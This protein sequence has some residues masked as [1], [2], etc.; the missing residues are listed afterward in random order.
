[1]PG[2]IRGPATPVIPTTVSTTGPAA[3]AQPAAPSAP[4]TSPTLRDRVD[5][6]VDKLKGKAVKVAMEEVAK[7]HDLGQGASFGAFSGTVKL[8]ERI[9]LKDTRS[10]KALV[11]GDR[12]RLDHTKSNPDAVWVKSGALVGASAGFPLGGASVGFNGS[13]EVTSIAAHDVNG[14][15]DVGAAVKAQ[16]K[17]MVLPLDAEGLQ[18]LEAAPGS[19]WMFRGTA[20]ASVSAGV[21]TSS[22]VGNDLYSASVN[23]GASV[24][25][26]AN[27]VFTKNVKVLE[28]GKVYVQ[29]ARQNN[30]SV[31]GSLGL[32][33][34]VRI[35]AGDEASDAVGGG[36]GG[37]VADRAAD[38]VGD[39]ITDLTAVDASVNASVSAHQKVLGAAVLD[40]NTPHGRQAYDLIIRSRPDE[41]A[42]Y[43][44]SSGL[45]VKYAE[46]GSAVNSGASLRFGDTNL[47]ATSTMKGTTNGTLEEPGGTTLLSQADFGRNVGGALPRL[48]IGEERQ[49][50]VRAG[51]VTRNGT[52]EQGLTLSLKVQDPKLKQGELAQ[53]DRFAKGMGTPLDKL[54]PLNGSGHAGKATYDVQVALTDSHLTQF[55]NR[56]PDDMKLAFG[57]ALKEIDGSATMP[58]WLEDPS[59]F[60][61]LKNDFEWN[62]DDTQRKDMAVREYKELTGGRDLGQDIE[63]LAAIERMSKQAV[64]ARGKPVAEWGKLLESVGKQSSRDVRA[65]LL[66]LRRLS[67][68]ELVSLN[69][70]AG[71]VTATAKPEAAATKTIAEI[72]G[73]VIGPPA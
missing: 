53:L 42:A 20:G 55:R 70:N 32:S 65:A 14:A 17:S 27:A 16:A 54:P 52:T 19:E 61:H 37:R 30:E 66:A 49:V 21:G 11:E 71:G 51:S 69:L 38:A 23:V 68:A 1:M 62:N 15:R 58:L 2:P 35:D 39:R 44:Q 7:D 18:G 50:S 60:A 8:S 67:G 59:R 33:A 12:R 6:Q 63:S 10:F 34:R 3:P 13:M 5:V 57:V 9:A 43:I 56:S 72:V 26:N 47:L 73:P 48:F 46:N 29:V 45:G 64:K 28:D 25:A 41:A 4:A 40:L 24:S 36:L 22:T 31:G